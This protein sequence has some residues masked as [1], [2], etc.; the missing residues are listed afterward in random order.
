[1]DWSNDPGPDG[2]HQ[3]QSQRSQGLISQQHVQTSK[4]PFIND[5]AQGGGSRGCP[6][7]DSMCYR[8]VGGLIMVIY[9]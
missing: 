3:V 6:V 9:A 2:S 8:G 1:M 4:G 5:V 7:C